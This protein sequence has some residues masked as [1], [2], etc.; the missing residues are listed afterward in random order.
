METIKSSKRLYCNLCEFSATRSGHLSFHKKT[1]HFGLRFPCNV[2]DYKATRKEHLSNH[3]KRK[4]ESEG[5]EKVVCTVCN[6]TLKHYVLENHMKIFHS[7]KQNQVECNLCGGIY[8][9]ISNLKIHQDSVHKGKKVHCPDCGKQF[10]GKR[11][12]KVHVDAIHKG[13][14]YKCKECDK[15][16]ALTSK[17]FTVESKI[18]L[19][20]TY[21]EEFIPIFQT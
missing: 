11:D 5:T 10:W 14:K 6:K 3:V 7:G 13:L 8:S 20:A 21:V 4:H 2:C 18:K 15:E 1:K 12:L 17:S 9:N 16:I 19:N